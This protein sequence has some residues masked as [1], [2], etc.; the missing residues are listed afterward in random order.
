M[1]IWTF[2]DW[3]ERLNRTGSGRIYA[4][5]NLSVLNRTNDDWS[6]CVTLGVQ[7]GSPDV[8]SVR[9][10]GR[11]QTEGHVSTGGY[12]QRWSGPLAIGPDA[13]RDGPDRESRRPVRGNG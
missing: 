9:A 10:N 4:F 3:S 5:W 2:G 13:P 1:F 11:F 7:T 12:S 8:R 6:G